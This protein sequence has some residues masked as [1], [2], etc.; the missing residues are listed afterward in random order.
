[1]NL[2]SVDCTGHERFPLPPMTIVN[3]HIWG[4]RVEV[5]GLQI[6]LQM[7]GNEARPYGDLQSQ[8]ELALPIRPWQG[9]EIVASKFRRDS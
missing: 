8:A 9:R 6:A 5:S 2:N 4:A 1:M 3:D 7:P